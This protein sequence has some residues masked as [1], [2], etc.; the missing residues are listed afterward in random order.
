M[1]ETFYNY[2]DFSEF[3]RNYEGRVFRIWV[4]K[5]IFDPYA[6]AEEATFAI[7]KEAVEL[8]DNDI[9]V[10]FIPIE[11]GR[12]DEILNEK[13]THIEYEKLSNLIIAYYDHDTECREDRLNVNTDN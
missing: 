13:Y 4:K 9:L 8:P 11:G 5:N 6:I 10:G 2:R 3:C 12:I 1:T 7:F